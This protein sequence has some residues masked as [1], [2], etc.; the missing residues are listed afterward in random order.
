MRVSVIIPCFNV[1]HFVV[2]AV[3]SVLAQDH[4]DLELICVNDGSTDGTG[5]LLEGLKERISIPYHCIHR[6][7]GGAC[8][9]RNTGIER[10]T[11]DYLE[12][13]DADDR[14]MA[15]KLSHQVELVQRH[16]E[17]DLI[18]GSSIIRT[19]EGAVFRT[20]IL[21]GNGD[22]PWL[23]LM[24]HELGGS[25]QNL[26]KHH[27]VVAAGGWT[28]G[29]GSSQEYDLM[30]RMLQGGARLIRDPEVL[31]EIHQRKTGSISQTNLDRNW[32]RFVDLRA[33]VVKHMRTHFPDRDQRAYE[34]VLF[35]S[36]RTYYPFNPDDAVELHRELF[37]N[38]FDPA[39]STATGR[40]YLLLHKLFGFSMANRLRHWASSATTG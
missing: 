4:A 14:L 22:D 33:R 39:R 21:N 8:A 24:R 18:A 26:W 7:N 31:T 11:G 13:L 10:S 5:A 40:G 12:F 6:A 2:H 23:S 1:E 9:A 37:P 30:F 28:E 38:G 20:E 3:D 35:D 19:A 32:R 34:Q 15:G 27:A 25:P 17:P 36:L 16:D 29:L